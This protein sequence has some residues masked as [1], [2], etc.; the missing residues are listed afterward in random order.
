MNTHLD[1]IAT[2]GCKASIETMDPNIEDQTSDEDLTNPLHPSNAP[3]IQRSEFTRP[4]YT[5][6]GVE[7]FRFTY[8]YELLFNQVRDPEDTGLFTWFAFVFLLHKNVTG[9]TSDEHRK[10]AIELAWKVEKF[11]STLLDWMDHHGPFSNADKLEAKRIYE[12]NMKAAVESAAEPVPDRN[13]RR[14]Q[15]K[16]RQRK[17]R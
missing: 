3:T 2:T 10:W 11:R 15:K 5:F 9:E 17:P 12:E 14:S 7:L 6:K 13:A 16:T 1:C 8:G 4:A